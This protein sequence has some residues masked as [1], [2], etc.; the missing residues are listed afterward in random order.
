MH[1]T[2]RVLGSVQ[3]Q[4]STAHQIPFKWTENFEIIG[5]EVFAFFELL[6]HVT[7]NQVRVNKTS[8]KT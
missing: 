7:L 1:E 2:K 8:I 3:Q 5:A 6:D 4:V